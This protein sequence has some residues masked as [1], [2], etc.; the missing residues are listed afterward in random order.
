MGARSRVQ[1]WP[2]CH[3]CDSG[4]LGAGWLVTWPS[5]AAV[6][7]VADAQD[8]AS[9]ESW[10]PNTW[11]DQVVPFQRPANDWKLLLPVATQKLAAGHD[12]PVR[13]ALCQPAGNGALSKDQVLP[14]QWN[15]SGTGIV[16]SPLSPGTVS[17]PTAVQ[18]A[19]AGH[20]TALSPLPSSR[21]S[22]ESVTVQRLPSH[23]SAS[24]CPPAAPT[25]IHESAAGQDTAPTCP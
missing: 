16:L 6:H 7:A 5:P 24:A 14:S 13:E 2:R 3:F 15:A 20:D 25:A 19:G 22:P 11:A 4:W 18:S 23:C 9:R 10:P 12:T 17:S 1:P 8:T 21:D